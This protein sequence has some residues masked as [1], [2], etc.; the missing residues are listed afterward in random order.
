M[1]QVSRLLKF[2]MGISDAESFCL[3]YLTS[4]TR[5]LEIQKELLFSLSTLSSCRE[6]PVFLSIKKFIIPPKILNKSSPPDW[7]TKSI[8]AAC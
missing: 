1:I 7:T 5:L 3:E 6:L 4:T 8:L 2:T